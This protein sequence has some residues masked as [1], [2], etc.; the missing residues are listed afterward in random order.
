MVRLCLLPFPCSLTSKRTVCYAGKNKRL[1]RQQKEAVMKATIKDVAKVAGV[2]PSTVSRALHNSERISESMRRHIQQVAREMD[3]H[4]NQM[5]RSLVNR[6]TRIIGIVFPD[7]A[8]MN[9]GNPFY[10]AVLQGLGHVASGERYQMLLITGSEDL[11]AAE[12]ARAA[13]DSGYVS[14]LILLAAE[15]AP[16]LEA[17]VPVV[18]IGHP[19]DADKR[20]YVD[21]DNV[22]AGYEAAKYLL[23]NGHSSI[24]LLGFD[25]KYVFTADRRRGVRRALQQAGLNPNHEWLFFAGACRNERERLREVFSLPDRPTAVVCMDDMMAIELT[26]TLREFGLRV[27]QDVS[28]ISFNNTEIGRY[29]QPALTT[30]DVHPYQLGVKAMRLM[31]DVISGKAEAP[32]AIDVPFTL[33]PRDSVANLNTGS[34][35]HA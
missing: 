29:H 20:C 35:N 5:A 4:P 8:G 31:L 12:A 1:R 33:I 27:P 19:T 22:Q 18:V 14:G 3:F 28:L 34:E 21:N 13:M 15:D 26:R 11:S 23:E 25:S 32:A 9:L 6:E 10:P 30:F 16:P 24:G 7:D 2:S 17:N